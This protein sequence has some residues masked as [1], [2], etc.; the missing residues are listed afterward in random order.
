VKISKDKNI[1][2]YEIMSQMDKLSKKYTLDANAQTDDKIDIKIDIIL[3]ESFVESDEYDFKKLQTS[4]MAKIWDNI[5]DEA[6]DE[7]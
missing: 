3:S 6:W 1:K 4:S 5:E 2:P 7:L